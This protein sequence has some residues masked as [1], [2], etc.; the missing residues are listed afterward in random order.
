MKV[1]LGGHLSFYEAQ[2]R[3]N[4]EIDLRAPTPVVE[5]IRAWGV[6][7]GEISLAAVNNELVDLDKAIVVDSDRLGLYPPMGGGSGV[8]TSPSH[9]ELE[10]PVTGSSTNAFPE[11]ITGDIE[12]HLT[13]YEQMLKIRY[14]EDQV[15]I[16][17]Q[18]GQMPGLA[19]LYS[20][21]EAVAVGVC[22]AL[23]R[24]DYITST[25]RGHGHCL[26]KGAQVDNM[27]AELL[28]KAAGYCHGKG[29]SMHIAD[30]ESSN[31]GATRAPPT[32]WGG[33]GGLP[34]PA[35]LCNPR[36]KNTAGYRSV[37]L[38]KV[39]WARC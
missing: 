28:G 5:L 17:Y 15:N 35:G 25:H 21:Q 37:S 6:P 19:H 1:H 14:F 33:S 27:F 34:P 31:L 39:R 16:L 18:T 11:Q 30:P 36:S 3:T 22:E 29:G 32:A 10:A 26:A 23:E 13:M 9:K 7:A 12:Q 38:A 20:G 8:G 4:F 24:T 2:R